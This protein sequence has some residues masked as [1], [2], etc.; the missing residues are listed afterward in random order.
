MDQ[1]TGISLV[2]KGMNVDIGHDFRKCEAFQNPKDVNTKNMEQ[3]PLSAR[4]VWS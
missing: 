1:A 3:N 4:G 2:S